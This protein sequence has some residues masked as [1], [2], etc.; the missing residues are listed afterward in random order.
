MLVKRLNVKNRSCTIGK[1]QLALL[2]FFQKLLG[3]SKSIMFLNV[4]FSS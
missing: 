3:G 4:I 2:I 1:S